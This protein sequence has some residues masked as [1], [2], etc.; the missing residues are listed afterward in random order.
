MSANPA[1]VGPIVRLGDDRIRLELL[2]AVGARI[3]RLQV[4]GHDVIR[5]PADLARHLDDPWYW[6]S[7]PMAP[8]CNRIA[9]GRMVVAGRELDLPVNFPDGTAIHG[10]V[11]RA[12]WDQVDAG[13][14]RIRAGGDG[15][16]WPYEVE[17]R[18]AIAG[19]TLDL[20]LALANLADDPMPAGIGIHP[21]F[22]KPLHVAIGARAVHADNLA[23]EAEPVAV[24]G[25]TDRRRLEPM[26]DDLDGTWAD[27]TEP[28]I[29]LSWPETGLG[30]VI[31]FDAPTRFVTA[32]SPAV[33]DAV[34]VEPQTHAPAGIRRLIDDEPGALALLPAGE[35]L[36]LAIRMTF[37]GGQS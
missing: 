5:S 10:Q 15:W 28:P 21:W 24:S 19:T 9:P 20:T 7:Y 27:L 30:A 32:A 16:P 12:A 22:R 23:T 17:Q 33:V 1:G 4:D 13:T 3:H 18:F 26:P 6:G 31:G 8:W 25:L 14:F 2:P 37:D 36:T 29:E 35:H 34:A 11:A